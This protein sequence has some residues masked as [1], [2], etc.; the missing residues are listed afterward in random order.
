MFESGNSAQ[1]DYAPQTFPFGRVILVHVVLG[2]TSYREKS[3]VLVPSKIIKKHENPGRPLLFT[4][5]EQ[6]HF[7]NHLNL[8]SSWGYPFDLLDL[9]LFLKAYLDKKGVQER[10]LKNN[11][12]GRDWALNFLKRRKMNCPTAFPPI[13]R[14][15][16]HRCQQMYWTVFFAN[17]Q[18]MLTTTDPSL[19]V[20]F[21]E[22]NLTDNPGNK[23]FIFKRGT[24]YPESVINS[25][26]SAIS[27]ISRNGWFD[28][29]CFQD[30]F[31]T[32]VVPFFK[33]KE[34]QKILIGDNLTSHF[35]E[36][37]L[38][39]CQEMS[40]AFI[41]LPRNA[42]HVMQP[43]DVSFYAP[44]KKYW[45]EILT[46]WKKTKARKMSCLS[47]DVFPQML[48]ELQKKLDDNG[49][50]SQNL[51]SGFAKTGL[52][53]FDPSRPKQRLP[54]DETD[55]RTPSL[56]TAEAATSNMSCE[57]TTNSEIESATTDADDDG[58]RCQH[59]KAEEVEVTF[60]L[61]N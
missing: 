28:S 37:V 52:Y 35:S 15:K 58:Q 20:N 41:C 59:N 4:E 55:D 49:K 7:V 13:F 54:S 50:G 11:T 27:L 23:K 32:V 8:V 38:N 46:H 44:L 17:A 39:K 48:N 12:P 29:V 30:W 34:G 18:E 42:T 61:S 3:R 14:A 21:D 60:A 47:K 40:I 53:P 31:F 56:V 33:N 5:E 45:R 26:K 57:A 24:R 51:I 1:T 16:E 43:L 9:R 2:C 19:M 6:R 36:A 25:T 22:T 10:R